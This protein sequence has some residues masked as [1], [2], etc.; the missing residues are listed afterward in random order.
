MR[1]AV[2]LD[3]DG[4]LI[5]TVV[6]NGRPYPIKDVDEMRV[7]PEVADACH[8]LKAAGYRLIVVTNQPDIARGTANG[9]DVDA[10]NR[11]LAELLP[12]DAV[13]VC[14]HDDSDGCDCR[15]PKPGLLVAAARDFAIDLAASVMVGDRWRDVQAGHAAGCATVFID[16]GYDEPRPERSDFVCGSLAEITPRLVADATRLR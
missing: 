11:R 14:P 16:Y 8:R 1:R 7:L 3:R 12:L 10:I 6:R 9:G 5:D 15:K 2:F 13:R 4:V